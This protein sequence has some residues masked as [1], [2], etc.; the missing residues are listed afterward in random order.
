[1]KEARLFGDVLWYT[2]D[3]SLETPRERQTGH[4]MAMCRKSGP[5]WR[6]INMHNSLLP[7]QGDSSAKAGPP[8]D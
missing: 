3:Y 8:P 2:Y 6:I 7:P 1:M 5:R 4:G